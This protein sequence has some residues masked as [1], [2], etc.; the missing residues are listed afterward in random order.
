MIAM[1]LQ[2]KSDNMKVLLKKANNNPD[3]KI[4]RP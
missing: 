1:K 2:R 4:K 3:R